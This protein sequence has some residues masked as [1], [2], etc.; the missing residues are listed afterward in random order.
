MKYLKLILIIFLLP[1]INGCTT[2]F[3]PEIDEYDELIVVE[4]LFTNENEGN[5][6]RLSRTVPIGITGISSP[7]VNA[8]IYVKD[9]LKRIG[10]FHESRPGYY[11]IDS[12]YF[13]GEE[14]RTYTLYIDV[15][16]REYVSDPMLMKEVQPIDSLYADFEYREDAIYPPLYS[17]T[18]YFD[19]N[20]PSIN[21]KY[22]RWTYE[23]VWE[24]HLPWHYPPDYKSIC[25]LT[26]NSSDI[27]IKNNSTLEY[28]IIEKFPLHQV[29]NRSSSRLFQKYSIL[30]RQYSI[31]EKEYIFWESMREMTEE[32]GGLYDPVPQPLTGNITCID[33]PA[34]P[35]LGFFSVS[36]VSKKRLF[37]ENDT[38][39]YMPGGQYCVTDTA[40]SIEEISGLDKHVFILDFIDEGRY[41]LLTRFEQCADCRLF[42]TNVRPDFW[43][44]D[45]KY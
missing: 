11:L 26:E 20:D 6:V 32:Q 2:K 27:I 24:Y 9:D 3:L 5:F 10:V 35:V 23:E 14:G 33:D 18:I 40:Y 30:L 22:F 28:S 44:E 1:L 17:Y 21:N 16:G 25:W 38:L 7:V 45:K 41:Y 39:K 34:E 42:G 4:A 8:H 29:D 15:E 36:A 19:S 12:N 31:S 13:P 43:D 37:I